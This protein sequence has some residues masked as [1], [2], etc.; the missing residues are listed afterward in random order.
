[1]YNPLA[2]KVQLYCNYIA[3]FSSKLNKKIDKNNN[4]TIKNYGRVRA[5]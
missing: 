3:K 5:N 1:M 4:K 2:N